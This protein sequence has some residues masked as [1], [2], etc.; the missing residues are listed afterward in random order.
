MSQKLLYDYLTECEA[1]SVGVP[2]GKWVCVSNGKFAGVFDT[3]D[4]AADAAQ[5]DPDPAIHCV[6]TGLIGFP[7]PREFLTLYE[8]N[9]VCRAYW[10]RKKMH[11]VP[12]I[13]DHGPDAA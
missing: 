9:S 5:G 1:L 3:Q 7:V 2:A 13:A 10:A 4:E 6:G 12:A 8:F 11:I